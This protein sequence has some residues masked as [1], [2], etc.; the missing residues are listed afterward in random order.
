[1]C[2]DINFVIMPVLDSIKHI[3]RIVVQ[4]IGIY[5]VWTLIHYISAH[6]YVRICAPSGLYGFILSIILAPSHYCYAVRWALFNGGN[7]INTMWIVLGVWIA[8]YL[9]MV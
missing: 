8:N 2:L 6:I 7:V 1:M 3:S 9:P 5:V 4:S